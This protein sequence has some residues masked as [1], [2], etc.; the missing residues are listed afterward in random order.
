MKTL[1]SGIMMPYP[2]KKIINDKEL[3]IIPYEA[4]RSTRLITTGIYGQIRHPIQAGALLLLAFGNG[5]YT[6]ERLLCVLVMSIFILIGVI[7][8]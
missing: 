6:T 7:L 5:V 2:V 3:E 8:E 1:G 4:T